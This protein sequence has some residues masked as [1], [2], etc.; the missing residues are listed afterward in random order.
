MIDP[1]REAAS[2][3]VF[4]CG[5]VASRAAVGLVVDGYIFERVASIVALAV[6][7][8]AAS[9]ASE[10]C[11]NPLI[12]LLFN[13]LRGG[14]P[15]G[16]RR[17]M[18]AALVQAASMAAVF[19]VAARYSPTLHSIESMECAHSKELKGSIGQLITTEVLS[20]AMSL[21]LVGI[22]AKL[23]A[24]RYANAVSLVVP[25]VIYARHCANPA[26]A[27]AQYTFHA[28]PAV[29]YAYIV[30]TVSGASLCMLMVLRLYNHSIIENFQKNQAKGEEAPIETKKPDTEKALKGG[31]GKLILPRAR[32]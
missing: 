11:G 17:V 14:G 29:L 18:G 12:L 13:T 30:G 10:S 5:L 25:Q 31:K 8:G 6:T 3:G 7:L 19:S 2:A 24:P 21:A 9:I 32:R 27:L 28:N 22:L 20:V 23:H 15:N 1:M 26:L 4:A 16:L